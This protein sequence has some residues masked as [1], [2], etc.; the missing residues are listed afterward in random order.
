LTWLDDHSRYALSLTAHHRVTGPA[1]VA[2][3]RAAVSGHG[4]PASALTDN[5]MVFTTRFS[6][7]RGGRNGLEADLRRL[8]IRQKNG[9]PNHPQTQGKV[10]RF[11]QTLKN[12]LAAQPAQPADLAQLQALL[13]AFTAVY[14]HQRPHRSLP[15]RATPAT[16]YAARPKAVAGDR[17]RD[18]VRRDKISSTG[19]VT[20]APAGGCTTSASAAPTPEPA[21][22]SSSRTC[23]SASS[24]PRPANYSAN[25]TSTSTQPSQGLPAHRATPR[26]EKKNTPDQMKVRGVLDVL[27]HHRVPPGP[28][29]R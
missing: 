2:A 29:T 18:R 24:T 27:R 10:E 5:G 23:T 13:D 25:S 7:G 8:G 1:V 14:N 9:R 17:A 3:F 21:S 20:L 12:W 11:Q 4:A 19:N 15:H 6:G 16:S 28:A 22:C 26:P